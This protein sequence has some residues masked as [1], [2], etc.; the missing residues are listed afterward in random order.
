MLKIAEALTVAVVLVMLLAGAAAYFSNIDKQPK[1]H[2]FM[3]E[4]L[5][6]SNG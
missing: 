4:V 3:V 6:V 5:E 2:R 1:D